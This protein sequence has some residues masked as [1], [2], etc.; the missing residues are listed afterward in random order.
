MDNVYEL[1]TAI[2]NVMNVSLAMRMSKDKT[3]KRLNYLFNKTRI[4]LADMYIDDTLNSI[5]Y[6]VMMDCARQ[7]KN[8]ALKTID[9]MYEIC[10]L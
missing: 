5:G 2:D 7:H 3:L 8:D 6:T 9:M 1:L 4:I 10:D